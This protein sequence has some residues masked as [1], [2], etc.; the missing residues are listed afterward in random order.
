APVNPGPAPVNPEP[1]PV[2][3]VKPDSEAVIVDNG[4][5]SSDSELDDVPKTG[6]DST[7]PFFYMALALMSLITIGLCLLGSKKKNNI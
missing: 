6:D 2:K 4:T 5:G 7:S 1:A 3:P